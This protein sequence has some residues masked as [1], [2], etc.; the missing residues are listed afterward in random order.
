[1]LKI[2]VKFAFTESGYI[3][4]PYWPELNT[5]I[6]ISKDVHPKLGDVKKEAA[7]RAA[8]EKRGVK[9]PEEYEA[10]KER[11]ERPFYTIDDTANGEIVIP[12]RV[13]QSFINH[14]SMSVPKALP[15]V[16]SKGLTFIGIKLVD[17]HLRTGKTIRDAKKFERFVKLEESNQRSFSVSE[18]L[19][20]FV[21]T[22]TIIL[23]QEVIKEA[24]LRK[25]VEWGAK[26]VGIGGARPQGFGRFSV[27]SWEP[28]G[29]DIIAGLAATAD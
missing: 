8:C 2:N 15:R 4:K 5:L 19:A 3:G 1:M 28:I 23:D 20:D 13:F 14:T 26:W 18:Y 10:L 9:Y 29:T 7:L 21:A 16:T 12:Q 25:L 24:D 22:G 6:N 11:A 17:G 27:I